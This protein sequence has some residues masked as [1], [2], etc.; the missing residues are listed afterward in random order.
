LLECVDKTVALIPACWSKSDYLDSRIESRDTVRHL[1]SAALLN[2]SLMAKARRLHAHMLGGPNPLQ[3]EDA[4]I[5]DALTEAVGRGQIYAV[6]VGQ[7]MAR[8]S[9]KR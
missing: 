7:P 5:L 4:Q 2:A 9:R 1:L 6:A 8:P 3:R